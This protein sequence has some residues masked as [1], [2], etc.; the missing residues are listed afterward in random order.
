ML[1]VNEHLLLEDVCGVAVLQN[2]PEHLQG[3]SIINAPDLLDEV[4]NCLL[5]TRSDFGG[6]A[7][8]DLEECLQNGY[9]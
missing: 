5:R 2:F 7:N 1:A 6:S 4:K 9:E 3:L 8:E